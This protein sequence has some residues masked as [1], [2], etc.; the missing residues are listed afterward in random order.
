VTGK[1]IALPSEAEWEKAARGDRDQRAYPWGD[2]FDVLKCN[3]D[4]LG[5]NDT[6]PV[7]VF[8]S[9]ASPYGC[10]DMAGNGCEWTRS[11]WGEGIEK[12]R[13][14]YPYTPEDGREDVNAPDDIRR[15]LRGGA[16]RNNLWL[17]RSTYRFR[18]GPLKYLGFRV[19]VRPAL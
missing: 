8:P 18:Y 7:G 3:S 19:V 1:A 6:T 17:V 14:T 4:E 11:L 2:A 5:L 9:G 15:V 16:F 12:P 10:L 13:F